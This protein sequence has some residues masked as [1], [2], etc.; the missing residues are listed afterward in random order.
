MAYFY[1]TI[2]NKKKSALC[3]A[4]ALSY[5]PQDERLIDNLSKCLDVVTDEEILGG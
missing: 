1:K 5:S 4:K 2:P 3:A